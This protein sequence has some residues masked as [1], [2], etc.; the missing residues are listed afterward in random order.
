MTLLEA[1]LAA[2]KAERI[3]RLILAHVE[4]AEAKPEAN[5]TVMVCAEGARLA[6]R[7]A[8]KKAGLIPAT[9]AA[10]IM[11][12]TTAFFDALLEGAELR[13]GIVI[14]SVEEVK[15]T[16]SALDAVDRHQNEYLT[17]M[18]DHRRECWEAILPDLASFA[19]TADREVQN[20][21]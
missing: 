17:T 3:A 16:Q 10:A 1:T 4:A 21:G 20:A 12:A 15:A 2:Q 7:Y 19:K 14:D 11:E 18:F 13:R 8:E 9:Q 6:V 5:D